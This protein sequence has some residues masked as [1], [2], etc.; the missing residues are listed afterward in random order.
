MV[1]FTMKV[2]KTVKAKTIKFFAKVRDEGS[3][4][5]IADEGTVLKRRDVYVPRFFPD[6]DGS[7]H[8]GDYVNLEIELDTGRIVNWRKPSAEDLKDF[9]NDGEE[10]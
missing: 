6:C 9:V 1:D 5:L 4:E 8:Y 7:P 10:E 3:Y 2:E